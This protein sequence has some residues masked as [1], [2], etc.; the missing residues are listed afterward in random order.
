MEQ[1]QLL[2]LVWHNFTKKQ[3]DKI[4]MLCIMSLCAISQDHHQ[5]EKVPLH[6]MR[7]FAILDYML[8]QYNQPPRELITQVRRV[9]E[10]SVFNKTFLF[11]VFYMHFFHPVSF[12]S[13]LFLSFHQTFF[14]LF[15]SFSFH[16]MQFLSI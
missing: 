10:M 14:I 5:S 3:R 15:N 2:L 6:L 9:L 1:L 16:S 11:N 13:S 12:H 7:L 4:L 8:Y